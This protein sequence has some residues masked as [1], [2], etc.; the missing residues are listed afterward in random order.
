MNKDVTDDL[1][2]SGFSTVV[3]LEARLNVGMEI[4]DEG[5]K[6]NSRNSTMKK[7]GEC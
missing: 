3:S 7:S 6:K 4:N 5:M 2:S 1:Y